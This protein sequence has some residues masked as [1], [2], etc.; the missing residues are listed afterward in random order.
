MY[1]NAYEG[2]KK[3]FTAEILALVAGV[4]GVAAAIAMLVSISSADAGND[5]ALVVV[6]AAAIL[7]II[8]GILM[9]LSF[10]LNILGLIKAR[11]DDGYF[12]IA[13]ILTF[14]GIV[15]SILSSAF[16][17]NGV[18]SGFITTAS[19]V[20]SLLV[21]IYV[22]MGIINIAKKLGRSDVAE[23]GKTVLK[24]IIGVQ[25][26]AIVSSLISAI[27]RAASAQMVAG[28]LSLIG[29]V[30]SVVYYFI[31]LS[32]LGKAKNMLR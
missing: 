29:S 18:V 9:L 3:L 11:K 14:I 13:F 16:S 32:L 5:S 19:N 20:I 30:I 26:I 15:I 17:T 23:K 10:I 12:N 7:L 1:K 27:F 28:V 6:G 31:Y 4:V 24:L 22:V 8:V 25:L 21:T 2:I